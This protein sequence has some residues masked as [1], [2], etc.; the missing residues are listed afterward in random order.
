MASDIKNS[1]TDFTQP[2]VELTTI[3]SIFNDS[4]SKA[5]E[6][7]V[8]QTNSGGSSNRK[9]NRLS[10]APDPRLFLLSSSSSSQKK[11]HIWESDQP[12][13]L[14]FQH[15][16][17]S[18]LLT[19]TLSV[20]SAYDAKQ[21]CVAQETYSLLDLVDD[22][23][24]QN[25]YEQAMFI[26]S[27]KCIHM[28]RHVVIPTGVITAVLG[29][30]AFLAISSHNSTYARTTPSP[31][32]SLQLVIKLLVVLI[33]VACMQTYNIIGVMLLPRDFSQ[34]KN[35]YQSLAAVDDYGHVSDNANL[36]Y[37]IWLSQG[38]ALSLVYQVGVATV[39]L[40]REA[41][42]HAES[43]NLLRSTSWQL[44]HDLDKESRAMWYKSLYRLRI[45]TGIW[46]AALMSCLVIVASSQY[47]WTSLLG[48]YATHSS[49][50][51][52]VVAA[53][54][55]LGLAFCRRTLAAWSSGIV[56]A[57]LCAAALCMH[58][59]ARRNVIALDQENHLPSLERLL[60]QKRL[61]LQTEL[62][63]SILLSLL[64]GFNA[65]F[66][67]SVDGPAPTVGNLY[68]ASWL[69]FLLCIRICLACLEEYYNIH[70]NEHI[71]D[72]TDERSNASSEHSLHTDLLE[73]ERA[74]RTRGF[75]FLAIF[76]L[77]SVASAYDA[78]CSQ[79]SQISR[80]Q[81]YMI[82]APLIVTILSGVLFGLCLSKVFYSVASH[83]CVGG[84]LSIASFML[85]FINLILTM[86]S[87]ESWAV[88]G[89]G[90]IKASIV[91]PA[92]Y[93][94]SFSFWS[95]NSKDPYFIS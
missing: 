73:K 55:N 68:Y 2:D 16:L 31:I 91:Q 93:L 34:S 48:P 81:I 59:W 52:Q 42:N 24:F 53:Q 30:Y 36:Y 23:N 51:C 75:F 14:H 57:A 92:T 50:L 62:T 88:N 4:S 47:V 66:T 29:V 35:V 84:L 43:D 3:Y 90:E 33:V 69:S 28:F 12:D 8:N 21:E 63:F 65:V 37:M 11:N 79:N 20:I 19:S 71:R 56:A 39:R 76:S 82:I 86:H 85:W 6:L 61:P 17:G 32:I 7:T 89:I 38:L 94:S 87:S 74:K 26:E 13:L 44:S 27:G 67:T 49:Q 54:S 77:V 58:W 1:A 45:R 83:F 41:S 46:T 9:R 72:N 80:I 70:E 18:L 64:L 22:D 40:G 78:S 95:N 5:P 60:L 10:I 15:L 25:A